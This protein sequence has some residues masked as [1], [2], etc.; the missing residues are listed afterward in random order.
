MRSIEERDLVTSEQ[1]SETGGHLRKKTG[2]RESKKKTTHNPWVKCA[3]LATV[4]V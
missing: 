3:M 4:L 1:R 2:Y